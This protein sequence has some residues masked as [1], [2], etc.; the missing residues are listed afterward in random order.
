MSSNKETLRYIS[1]LLGS[2]AVMLLVL[3][4]NGIVLNAQQVPSPNPQ[5]TFPWASSYPMFTAITGSGLAPTSN[6]NVWGPQTS[7]CNAWLPFVMEPLAIADFMTGQLYPIL[8]VNWTWENNYH[9]LVVYLRKG[10]YFYWN[11][12]L[13][14]GT[15]KVILWPFT[16]KDVVVTFEDYFKI[17]GNP[18]NV[19]VIEINPYEVDFHFPG[20]TNVQYAYYTLLQTYIVPWEQY[21]NLSNPATA[22]IYPP[23]GTGPFYVCGGSS[24]IIYFCR[25]PYYWIPGRPLI[26][27]AAYIPGTTDAF[28]F[29]NLASGKAQWG[30]AGSTGSTPFSKLFAYANPQYYHGMASIGNG[31]G[32]QP[33]VL[34]INFAQLN[35]WPWNESWFRLALSLA[36]NRT[37]VSIYTQFGS[38]YGGP[39]TPGDF[40]PSPMEQEW[41]NST[42]ISLAHQVI[43]YN[44]Q[45]AR[46]ILEEHGFKIVNTTSGPQLLF[47][48]GTAFPTITFIDYAGFPDTFG[49][50]VVVGE[51][52]KQN[53]GI[54]V[55]AIS[56]SLSTLFTYEETGEEPFE[57]MFWLAPGYSPYLIWTT[58]FVPAQA[59]TVYP[60]GSY[61]LNVTYIKTIGTMM[62][63]DPGR[64]IPPSQFIEDWIKAGETANVT[65]L[66]KYYNDMAMMLIKELPGIPVIFDAWPRYEYEDQYYIGFST[67]E[68]FYTWDTEIWSVGSEL[69]ILNIAPRPL[70]M[71]QQQEIEYTKEAWHDLLAYLYGKATTATPPSLL[72]LLT[73]S[74][75]T[76]TTTTTST[77]TTTT[78]TTSV[79]TATVTKPVISTAL[80]AGIVI[81]VIVVVAVVAIIALRRR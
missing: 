52:W 73:P 49:V 62:Y 56:E 42:V 44:P 31:S 15:S 4:M 6:W 59:I 53:L 68:Y 33:G 70:G 34:W 7:Q 10:V 28:V 64:W 18:Y 67:P 80:I 11:G 29:E 69:M 37:A 23:V 36:I 20:L 60:N 79:T 75:V 26:P 3:V 38:P 76:T 5:P 74:T 54:T 17:Y 22:V 77:T 45:E 55:K 30:S 8:A 16:A 47:P 27:K 81:I 19:S 51:Q 72:A 61:Y 58:E 65:E 50:G 1:V 43:Q 57:L 2:V 12:T 21:A 46:K 71:T 78:S 9:D 14:N 25:N 13:P 48:N 63:D 24:T 40:L 39:P 32:G 35:W 41:L 66:K